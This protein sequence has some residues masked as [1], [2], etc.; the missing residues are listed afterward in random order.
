MG[1]HA[2]VVLTDAV[3]W[4][5]VPMCRLVGICQWSFF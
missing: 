4:S 3:G 2:K 1:E 5:L